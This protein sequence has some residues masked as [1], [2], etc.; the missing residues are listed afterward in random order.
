MRLRLSEVQQRNVLR[1]L[2][3]LTF[4]QLVFIIF[5]IIPDFRCTAGFDLFRASKHECGRAF[6]TGYDDGC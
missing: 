1:G 3:F 4:L 5:P 2:F 6:C